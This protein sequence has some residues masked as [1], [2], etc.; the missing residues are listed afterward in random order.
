[1]IVTAEHFYVIG[2]NVR[3]GKRW[4]EMSFA[5]LRSATIFA[6]D[7][8]DCY[9][10]KMTVFDHLDVWCGDVGPAEKKSAEPALAQSE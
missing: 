6:F 2:S 7:A 9:T 5:D 1:M 8:S 4:Y 3:T 10:T